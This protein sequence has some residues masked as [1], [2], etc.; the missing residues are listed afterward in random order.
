MTDTPANSEH[1]F[2]PRSIHPIK[3]GQVVIFSAEK[4]IRESAELLMEVM[5][6]LNV[7]VLREPRA[8]NEYETDLP[9]AFILDDTALPVVDTDAIRGNNPGCVIVLLTANTFLQSSAPRPS[10]ERFPFSASADL[11]FAY[12]SDTC[13]PHLIV[14][15]AV[16]AVE[17]LINIR[18]SG[19]MKRFVFLVVDDEPRWVSQFLPVL[20]NIIGQRAAVMIARTFEEALTFLFGTDDEATI[21]HPD[22]TIAGQG[23]DV[24]FLI[25]DLVFPRKNELDSD[26]CRDLI[27]LIT[28]RY[29]RIPIVIASKADDAEAFRDDFYILPKGDPGSL[30]ELKDHI[31]DYSGIGDFLIIDDGNNVLYRITSIHEL[32]DV[33]CLAEEESP[34]GLKILDILEVYGQRDAF[35][36]W[37]YMHSYRELGDII[38]P[39]RSQGL[40]LISFLKEHIAK[41]IERLD[42]T[43]LIIGSEYVYTLHDLVGTLQSVPQ[44]VIQKLA[45]SDVISSWLDWQGYTLLAE[46]VRPIHGIGENLREAITTVIDR[47]IRD[48]RIEDLSG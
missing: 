13:A 1:R 36:T 30:T 6:W 10:R 14:P 28:Q 16:R 41:E 40:Q 44:E 27:R 32:H 12:D 9:L 18:R 23:D 4:R 11:V 22:S 5:P 37:L 43:P 19:H 46:E 35:S 48:Y 45:D 15:A 33:L 17:D 34:E 24:V 38:R 20:Y 2:R 25:T 39:D 47:W 26:S 7:E 31:H 29:P 21:E 3:V 42:R 8:V